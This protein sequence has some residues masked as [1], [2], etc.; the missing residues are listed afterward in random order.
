MKHKQADHVFE[1][2]LESLLSRGHRNKASRMVLK[3]A[4]T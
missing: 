1:M 2:M 4:M 3:K